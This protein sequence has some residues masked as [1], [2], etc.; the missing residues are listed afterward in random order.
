MDVVECVP[1]K[2]VIGKQFRKEAKPILEWLAGL[3]SSATE[4]VEKGLQ[5]SG[6]VCSVDQYSEVSLPQGS[7]VYRNW[8]ACFNRTVESVLCNIIDVLKLGVAIKRGCSICT[9]C[10]N[11]S[12]R[13]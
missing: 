7:L 6:Y 10:D 9:S 11:Q 4:E 5:T 3:D 12:L 13:T 8:W 2:G 1:D